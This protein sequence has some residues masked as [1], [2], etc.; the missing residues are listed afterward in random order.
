MGTVDHVVCVGGDGEIDPL[1]SCQGGIPPIVCGDDDG[2]GGGPGGGSNSG[3]L[4]TPNLGNPIVEHTVVGFDN[5]RGFLGGG[6]GTGSFEDDPDDPDQ[7]GCFLAGTPVLMIDNTLRSIED[8]EVGDMVI[9]MVLPGGCA[10]PFVQTWREPGGYFA[11][12]VSKTHRGKEPGYVEINEEIRCSA[13]H[14]FLVRRACGV[15]FVSA[16]HLNLKDVLV[17]YDEDVQ[18]NEVSRVMQPCKTF[19]LDIASS[20]TF[21]ACGVV[22]HNAFEIGGGQGSAGGVDKSSGSSFGPPGPV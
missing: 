6:H 15:G 22:V 19:N 10:D 18:V 11:G 4:I 2:G 7:P 3:G 9:A 13:D 20:H 5:G 12:R 1:G 8:I 17:G 21:V 16:E 14:P